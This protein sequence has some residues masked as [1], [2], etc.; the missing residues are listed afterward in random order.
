MI[1]RILQGIAL[2]QLISTIL[3]VIHCQINWDGELPDDE[4]DDE[5]DEEEDA[6]WP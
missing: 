1:I 4:D 6:D 2:V 5:D 3:F